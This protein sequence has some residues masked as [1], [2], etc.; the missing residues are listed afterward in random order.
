MSKPHQHELDDYA[1]PEVVYDDD[2]DSIIV[3]VRCKICG[4]YGSVMIT[5]ESVDWEVP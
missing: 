1:E 5:P 4:M 3:D 2:G